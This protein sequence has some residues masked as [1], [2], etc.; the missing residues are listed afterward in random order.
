MATYS[1]IEVLLK[2]YSFFFKRKTVCNID[3]FK[4][5]I[6]FLIRGS[7]MPCHFATIKV[8]QP[9]LKLLS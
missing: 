5:S 1:A 7:F 9:Y 6:D 4:G 3:L 2:T 8:V